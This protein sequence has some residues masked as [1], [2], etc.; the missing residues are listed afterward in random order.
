VVQTHLVARLLGIRLLKVDGVVQLAPA[1][2]EPIPGV[3]HAPRPMSGP[4]PVLGGGLERA[5]RLLE[6]GER[7]LH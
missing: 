2:L 7:R 1:R 6:D 3:T 5:A 4:A